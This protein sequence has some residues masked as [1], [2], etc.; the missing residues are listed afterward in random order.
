M[1]CAT[2]TA[3]HLHTSR[4]ARL[5]VRG[6]FL[7]GACTFHCTAPPHLPRVQLGWLFLIG[8]SWLACAMS[9]A[10]RLLMVECFRS[11]RATS[12]ARRLHSLAVLSRRV[13][14]PLRARRSPMVGYFHCTCTS[15]SLCFPMV[16]CSGSARAISSARRL[17]MVKCTSGARPNLR[18]PIDAPTE[19]SSIVH[20]QILSTCCRCL[21]GLTL[22]ATIAPRDDL[23]ARPN[24]LLRATAQRR[25]RTCFWSARATSTARHLDFSLSARLA[26]LGRRV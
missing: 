22:H 12:T 21:K 18:G 23:K 24:I 7:V 26:V 14:F 4:S 19:G 1:A 10:L 17:L 3:R 6:V 8:R 11:A 2:S 15:S 5:A 16:G 13:R 9:S 25:G 20:S